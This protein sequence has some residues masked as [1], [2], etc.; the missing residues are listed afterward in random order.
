MK[1]IIPV[2]FVLLAIVGCSSQKDMTF[3]GINDNKTIVIAVFPEQKSEY[4]M[5]SLRIDSRDLGDYRNMHLTHR[6]SQLTSSDG[7]FCFV[8]SSDGMTEIRRSQKYSRI[9]M[10]LS[11]DE[12]RERLTKLLEDY[13]TN[14]ETW[15]VYDYGIQ[16]ELVNKILEKL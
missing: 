8:M 5:I 13:K 14:A 16:I 1:K 15:M 11:A 12:M 7:E 6:G 10:P 4:R 2:F 9:Y 3:Y